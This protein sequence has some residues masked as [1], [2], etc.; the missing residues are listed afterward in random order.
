MLSVV[1]KYNLSCVVGQIAETYPPDIQSKKERSSR[2]GFGM[3][4]GFRI[5]FPSGI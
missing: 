2:L 1:K 5:I 3:K 4:D